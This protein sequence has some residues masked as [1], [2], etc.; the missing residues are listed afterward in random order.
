MLVVRNEVDP[1][2]EYH[3]DA[4]ASYFPDAREYDF[5]EEGAAPSLDGV[6]GV[7]LS[8]STAG[9][10]EAP[11]RPWIDA[12]AAFVR[13]LVEREIPTLGICFG[14]QLVNEALGGRVKA[15]E[16]I[17]RLVRFSP[18]DDPLFAGVDPIVP[19]VHGDF[20]VERGD[21]LERIASA[22]YYPEFGS[23]HRDA[24]IWTLQGHPEIGAEHV[25]HLRENVGWTETEYRFDETNVPQLFENFRE[26]VERYEHDS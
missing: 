26:L 22:E 13:E 21:G 19:A 11:D 17:H 23:R 14:H 24:P 1:E 15:R 5:P 18:A 9:V 3:C 10:Y 6:D 4:L 8:G 2:S 7:V 20:V 16:S 25:D 12:E